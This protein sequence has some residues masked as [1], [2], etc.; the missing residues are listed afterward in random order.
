M[1]DVALSKKKK[2]N[3]LSIQLAGNACCWTQSK[4][5]VR[6]KKKLK[7]KNS[8]RNESDITKNYKKV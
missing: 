5:H 7:K 4:T 3:N 1:K 8:G 6:L 2:L